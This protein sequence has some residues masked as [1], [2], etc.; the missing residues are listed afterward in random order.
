MKTTPP[1]KALLS[2]GGGG[3]AAGGSS[4]TASSESS[5]REPVLTTIP[6]RQGEPE[7]GRVPA[8]VTQKSLTIHDG[9]EYTIKTGAGMEVEKMRIVVLKMPGFL[10]GILR[11]IF[12]I[13][14]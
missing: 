1:V 2:E 8:N 12:K 14:S 6:L 10:G 7:I 5:E 4:A 13:R 9:G 3:K 11:R